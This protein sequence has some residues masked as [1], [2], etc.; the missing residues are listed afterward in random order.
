MRLFVSA[1][2]CYEKVLTKIYFCGIGGLGNNI[3]IEKEGARG[4][5]EK[6]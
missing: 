6:A 3:Q 1:C 4:D 5:Y 2:R